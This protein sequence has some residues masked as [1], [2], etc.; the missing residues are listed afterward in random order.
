[1]QHLS[2]CPLFCVVNLIGRS[3][4]EVDRLIRWNVGFLLPFDGLLNLLDR[5][6][7]IAGNV[8]SLGNVCAKVEE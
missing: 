7:V 3:F 6:G 4:N 2:K 8:K 5:V 1:M